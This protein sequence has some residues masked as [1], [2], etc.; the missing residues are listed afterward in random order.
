MM[1]EVKLESK[2]KIYQ[3]QFYQMNEIEMLKV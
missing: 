3:M 2:K 1:V